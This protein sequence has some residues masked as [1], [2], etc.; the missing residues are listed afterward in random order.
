MSRSCAVT[1]PVNLNATGGRKRTWRLRNATM[2]SVQSYAQA[3][4]S[5]HR[6]SGR[7]NVIRQISEVI[8]ARKKGVPIEEGVA[9]AFAPARTRDSRT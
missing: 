8:E 3:I 2:Q 6:R 7:E 9:R 5:L 4:L 1:L